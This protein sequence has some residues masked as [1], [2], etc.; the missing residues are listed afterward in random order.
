MATLESFFIFCFNLIDLIYSILYIHIYIYT[1]YGRII[2]MCDK[3]QLK[4][5]WSGK[6]F[7][8]CNRLEN[9]KH[10]FANNHVIS[11]LLTYFVRKGSI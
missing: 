4:W 6:S 10:D 2:F 11:F 3:I 5:G 7:E 8:L 9:G 1:K